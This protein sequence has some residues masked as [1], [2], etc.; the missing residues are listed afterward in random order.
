MTTLA[1]LAEH[2]FLAGLPSD[3]IDA[4]MADRLQATRVR[5]LGLY[6]YPALDT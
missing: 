4:V 5:L 6:A 1:L 2:P 3:W